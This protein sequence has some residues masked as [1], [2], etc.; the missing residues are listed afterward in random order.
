MFMAKEYKLSETVETLSLVADRLKNTQFQAYPTNRVIDE[1]G[2]LELI[3]APK[4]EAK[5]CLGFL[6][7]PY[8]KRAK[9]AKQRAEF[10]ECLYNLYK[11][12]WVQGD[13]NLTLT[14]PSLGGLNVLEAYKMSVKGVRLRAGFTD[15]DPKAELAAQ[16]GR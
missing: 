11:G 13:E 5:G 7:P 9:E 1:N 4:A 12:L 8:T 10:R 3:F 2:C 14:E 16:R 6:S 15:E